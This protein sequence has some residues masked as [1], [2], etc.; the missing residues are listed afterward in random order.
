MRG[1][2]LC[3]LAV[4]AVLAQD[5]RTVTS[6]DGQLEFR[7]FV[8][9]PEDSG[10]SR[11]AYQVFYRGKRM[12]DTSYLGLDI[13]L[14][15]PLLGQYI[16]LIGSA[17]VKGAGYNELDAHFMQNG[18]LGRLLDIEA[19]VFD[20][21]VEFRYVVPK[22]TPLADTFTLDDEKT[23]FAVEPDAALKVKMGEE[24]A[25]KYP[26]MSLVRG[27]GAVWVTRLERQFETTTPFSTSWRVIT[28]GQ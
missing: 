19:R 12:V 25:G 28:V 4:S 22:S 3:L 15:E 20:G 11:L 2:F 17:S 14:Q 16:G 7:L 8:G 1:I 27:P 26:P 21:K 10:L 18:S 9:Q 5:V 13:V 24:G 6:P 23:E